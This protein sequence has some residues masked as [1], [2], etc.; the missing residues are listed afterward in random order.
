MS[1]SYVVECFQSILGHEATQAANCANV[2]HEKGKYAVKT[3]S[4]KEI[5]DLTADLLSDCGFFVETVV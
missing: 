4:D 2:I 1:F 5:A 3:F